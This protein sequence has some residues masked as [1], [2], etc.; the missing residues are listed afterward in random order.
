MRITSRR[1]PSAAALLSLAAVLAGCSDQL[2]VTNPNNPDRE[3]VLKRATD[4]EALASSLYQQ[5]H[6]G[7]LGSNTVQPQLLTAAFENTSGLAN[8]AMGP[9]SGLPRTSISNQRGNPYSFENLNDFSQLERTART[10]SDIIHRIQDT[11]FTLGTRAANLRLKAFTYFGY[12][13]ALGDVALVY[14]SAAIPRP[15][16]AATFIPPLSDAHEVMAYALE[17]LDS[18]VVAASNDTAAFSGGFP[19]PATW[20]PGNALSAA[21]FVRLVRSYKAR[22][23]AGVARTPA[24]R[25]AVDWAAVVADARNGITADFKINMDPSTG[26]DV[27]WLSTTLHFQDVNWHQMTPYIIGMA[28]TSGAYDAWLATSRDERAAFLIVTPDLRMPQ[29]TTRTEQNAAPGKYLRNRPAGKDAIGLG[30]PNSQYDHDR[31]RSFAAASRKGAFPVMTK[32]EIDMLAA[33]GLI[34]T[35]DVAA[36]AALIDKTRVPNGLPSLVTAGATT[37]NSVVPGGAGC[38]PRVPVGPTFT[39]TAC[40]SVFEAMKWEKRMETAYSGYGMWFFD[41]RGWGDLPEGTTLEWPVPFQEM[42]ARREPF[43]DLGGIGGRSAAA[44]STYGFGTGSQ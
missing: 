2:Q 18:A 12:G 44:P 21:D 26:W 1:F 23:R 24:E 39:T 9:R 30:W 29:G 10:G 8:F 25:A 11:T 13:V 32:A 33:E 27:P 37:A 28:D 38:V 35:G 19:L 43:Y 4:V 41:S 42:D 20:L 22:L 17:Q 5:V 36:A 40:G 3:R 15:S 7:T 14:D 16:D 6:G 31:Y 34:R